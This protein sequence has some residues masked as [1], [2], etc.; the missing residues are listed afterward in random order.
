MIGAPRAGFTR[1]LGES[2]AAARA[3]SRAVG[4]LAQT[5]KRALTHRFVAG[6]VALVIGLAGTGL[7]LGVLNRVYPVDT[8]LFW[9]MAKVWG[10]VL[11][12]S[13]A[14][15]CMGQ[16]IL[17][18]VLRLELDP[19]ESA[20]QS[21]AVGVVAFVMSMYLGGA[22]GLF[23]P[24]FAVL[25]PL[26]FTAAG[27][28]SFLRLL[29]RLAAERAAAKA[30]GPF[31]AL[32]SAAGV[33]CV[34][35]VYL[36]LLTPDS[37][38]YDSTWSHLVIAQDYARNGRIVPFP[39]NYNMGVPH[40]ASIIHT[41]GWTVPGLGHPALRWMMA[42]HNEFG[43][44]VWTL[45]GVQAGVRRLTGE[46]GARAVW[47]GFFL[48][49]IIFVYDNNLGGA[50]DHIAA[51]F[52]V[53]I[54]LAALGLWETFTPKRAA[55]LAISAAGGL[56]T[57]YQMAYLFVP[58][59]LLLGVR[60]ALLAFRSRRGK[61]LSG[62]A[63]LGWRELKL[64]PLA[65]CAVGA[66][67]VAPHFVKNLIFYNNPVYPLATELFTGSWPTVPGGAKLIRYIFTDDNWRPKG[68]TL[69]RLWHAA[70]LFFRFSFE[71][72]YS[73]T[74]NV[75]AMGSLFTLLLPLLLVLTRARRIWFAAALA[76]GAIFIWAYTYNV[77]RNLQIFLPLMAC[78]AVALILRA[79][80]L[81]WLARAGLVPLVLLQVVWGSDALFYSGHDR[82]ESAVNLIRAGFEGNAKGRFDGYR[83]TFL[84]LKAAIPERARV[85]LHA[86]HVSL[87]ID[88]EIIQDWAGFQGFIS[89]DDLET[90]RELYDYYLARGI[91]HILFEPG[92]R[93]APSKQEEILFH[94]LVTSYAEKVGD[95]GHFRLL[96]M[97][98]KPPPTEAPYR[99]V[100]LGMAP[101]GDG[102]YPIDALSTHEGLPGSM[103][104]YASPSEPLPATRDERTQLLSRADAII[105]SSSTQL[106]S[107]GKALL[108]RRFTSVAR[109]NGYFTVYVRAKKRAE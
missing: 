7:Y 86:S 27:A 63:A 25:L 37:L 14:C 40:L 50:A 6:G 106:D 12:F 70:K 78:V 15:L 10:W 42:L 107:P 3:R 56:L 96:R 22:L 60:W 64:S 29:A 11:S 46:P 49:P 20:L 75:P 95:Y 2:I 48:F 79:W 62:D 31:G 80:R 72:H 39:G 91:T 73:F 52:A 4:P 34:A 100:M 98:E 81:G 84:A 5:I 108:K 93:G 51:F 17:E 90:P 8:W 89:Y 13:L 23:G 83:A 28:R 85:L 99:V 36:Q 1:R 55:L 45:V 19:L 76:S 24:V 87:G 71:P 41:W 67:L 82:L 101:Y 103:R 65:L 77:D 47:A 97:P 69:E 21:M 88:R 102:L 94:G 104:Q 74:R 92:A 61:P 66:L 68:T 105:V 44:F 9:S 16:L 53:P 57:K 32:V 26:A 35:M 38:N 33:G 109:Y 58:L 54:L 18:R 43:L 59:A 30:T